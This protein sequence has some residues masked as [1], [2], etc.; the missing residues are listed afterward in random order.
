MSGI[1]CIRLANTTEMHRWNVHVG[2]HL[3]SRQ[4]GERGCRNRRIG[5]W[6]AIKLY[7]GDAEYGLVWREGRHTLSYCRE[8]CTSPDESERTKQFCKSTGSVSS[9]VQEMTAVRSRFATSWPS[10]RKSLVRV[11]TRIG[12]MITIVN[13]N[14]AINN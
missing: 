6:Y 12:R 10:T 1:E 2:H 14:I 7:F 9:H 8:V 4:W 11:A 3:N 5:R 13:R